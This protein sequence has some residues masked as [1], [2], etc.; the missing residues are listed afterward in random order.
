MSKSV[1]LSDLR[2]YSMSWIY[3]NKKVLIKYRKEKKRKL[4]HDMGILT[5]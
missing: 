1:L 4:M 2:C 5:K 3:Y